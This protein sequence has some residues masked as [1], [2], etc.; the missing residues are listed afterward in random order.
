M[1]AAEVYGMDLRASCLVTL[2]GCETGRSEVRPG[3]DPVSIATSFLHSGA[4]AM[5]VSLW[6]VEDAATARLMELFYRKWIGE[7]TSKAR[8]L[9]EAKMELQ[10]GAFSHPRQ[11]AAFVLIGAP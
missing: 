8:A 11:W 7:K 2:S 6:K 1:R 5:L 3:D 9:R 10:S 4:G